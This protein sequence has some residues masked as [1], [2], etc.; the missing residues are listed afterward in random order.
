MNLP[1]QSIIMPFHRNKE[2]L[3]YTT[4]LLERIIPDSVEIIVVGN[5]DNANEL[6]VDLPPRIKYLQYNKSMLY[7]KTV[8][9]GVDA[10][11]GEIITL[12][13]QDIFGY[14]DW[15]RPLLNKLLSSNK[16][17]SVSSKLIN[18][19][20]NRIIDFGIEYSK[21]RIVHPF[22]GRKADSPLVCQ[23]YK[24]TS[25]TSATLMT[26]KSIYNDVGGMDLDMPYCCSD[27]DIGLKIGKNGLNNWVV[28]NSLAYHRGSS[29]N[30]NGKSSSFSHLKHD[31]ECMFWAKNFSTIEPTIQ[32]TLFYCIEYL[33]HHINFESMYYFINLSSLNEYEWYA[34]YLESIMSIEICDIHSY[35]QNSSHYSLPIQIYDEIPYTFMNVNVPII[36][37]VDYFPSLENN[38]IWSKM[39][40]IKK[41]LVLD[42][43]ANVVKLEDIIFRKC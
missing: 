26:W 13:D 11:K 15:Y 8:N 10:A 6:D 16:V 17:G 30:K 34:S 32:A 3:L 5:N 43:H 35:P 20:N 38:Y 19:I 4:K 25:T 42:S 29:S 28:S 37:F 1:T 27:C 41:D 33:K 7:S 31:S 23:D 12:C 9:I 24:V 22:R 36:Y 18:P 14:K 21:Y 2:M 40:N 39:R